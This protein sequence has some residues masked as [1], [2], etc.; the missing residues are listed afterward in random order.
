MSRSERPELTPGGATI[1]SP[2]DHLETKRRLLSYFDEKGIQLTPAQV[3]KRESDRQIEERVRA[4]FAGRIG[5]P[6]ISYYGTLHS[7]QLARVSP[8]Q[9]VREETVVDKAVFVA[10][11]TSS[12]AID[13]SSNLE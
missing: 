7:E 9:V 8:N 4:S 5:H 13:T 12:S 11:M 3:S 6:P 2:E 10:G 1:A